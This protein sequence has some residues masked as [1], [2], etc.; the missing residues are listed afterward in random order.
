MTTALNTLREAGFNVAVTPAGKL[1][2]TPASKLTP[3]LRHIIGAHRAELVDYLGREASNDVAMGGPPDWWH[4]LDREY[5]AHHAMCPACISAGRGYG[6]RCGVGSTLWV[7]YSNAEP[8]APT[9]RMAAPAT[10]HKPE[11]HASLLT[12]AT[13]SEINRMVDRLALFSARG[14]TEPQADRL[15]DKLL[16]RDRDGDNTGVC[17][18]CAHLSG[19]GPGRWRCG[20]RSPTS[21]ND[22]AGAHLGAAFVHQ[23]LHRCPSRQTA[24][25]IESN[26]P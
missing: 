5:Q 20:D 25:S 22:L 7:A 12:A 21:V 26:Q 19:T 13:P 15:T 23:S 24:T 17:A 3:E 10:Q 18:E 9:K 4:H 8:P 11:V 14:L 16:V 2:V 6:Q 1:A